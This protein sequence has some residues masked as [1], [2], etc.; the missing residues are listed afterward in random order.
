MRRI[1]INLG[2]E[3][4]FMLYFVFH[5]MWIQRV[6]TITIELCA[7]TSKEFGLMITIEFMT[8]YYNR[9]MSYYYNY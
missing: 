2:Y 7:I 3:I 1:L 4:D 5:R 8:Y 9:I 6:I